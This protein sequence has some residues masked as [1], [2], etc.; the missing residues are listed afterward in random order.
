[1]RRQFDMINAYQWVQVVLINIIYFNTNDYYFK[2]VLPK[3]ALI[4]LYHGLRF[5]AFLRL[6]SCAVKVSNHLLV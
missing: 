4:S 6:I 2:D 3:M 1:M 5:Y